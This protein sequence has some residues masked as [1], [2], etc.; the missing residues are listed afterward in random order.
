MIMNAQAWK[1]LVV[2]TWLIS[3]PFFEV[4]EHSELGALEKLHPS[5]LCI[6]SKN[7]QILLKKEKNIANICMI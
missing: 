6:A 3:L 4:G 7:R 2:I 5:L 1:K